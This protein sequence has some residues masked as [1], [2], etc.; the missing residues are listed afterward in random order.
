[1]NGRNGASNTAMENLLVPQRKL[2]DDHLDHHLDPQM[3]QRSL[4][5][6]QI[7]ANSTVTF[8]ILSDYHHV[9]GVLCQSNWMKNT[10]TSV[11]LNT[12]MI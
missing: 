10:G 12:S 9:G 1:M 6:N 2:N 11:N 8:G 3:V 4:E 7:G 5:V